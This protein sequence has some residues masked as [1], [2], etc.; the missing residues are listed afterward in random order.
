MGA[1]DGHLEVWVLLQQRV[2]PAS[3]ADCVQG[4]RQ[5]VHRR[6][7][8]PLWL[9]KQLPKVPLVHSF[10]GQEG[11]GKLRWK[12]GGVSSQSEVS[13]SSELLALVFSGTQGTANMGS[14][15]TL[16]QARAPL[17]P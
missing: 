7:C 2:L 4:A 9:R 13:Q 8:L 3:D 1:K 16:L 15:T 5:D 14:Y 6:G 11:P 12:P 10:K 17:L